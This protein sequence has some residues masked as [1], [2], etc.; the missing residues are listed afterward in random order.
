MKH[1]HF[2]TISSTQDYLIE[3]LEGSPEHFLVS[4]KHQSK[5]RGRSSNKW[6]SFSN[7]LAFSFKVAPSK[8]LTLTSLEIAI[9]LI[10]F[11]DSEKVKL[12]WPNDLLSVDL[13]KCGGILIQLID[14]VAIVGVG[15][16]WGQSVGEEHEEYKTGK[17]EISS[18]VLNDTEFETLPKAIYEFI[19]QN[20]MEPSQI[21]TDWNANCVHLGKKVTILD[22]DDRVDGIFKGIGPAGEAI[23]ENNN[24]ELKI[25]SGSLIINRA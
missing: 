19:L 25:Y 18:A 10:K 12:K 5:G 9:L 13:N 4:A 14:G 24:K 6:D 16:N 11:I 17:G 15:L 23:I 21:I 3:N 7:S 8:V 20:R 2:D 1:L 22:G